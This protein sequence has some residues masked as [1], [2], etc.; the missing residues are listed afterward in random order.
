MKGV[1]NYNQRKVN[2]QTANILGTFNVPEGDDPNGIRRCFEWYEWA[3]I[4]TEKTSFQMSINPDPDDPRE[5]LTDAEALSYAKRLME[6]LGYND[7]PIVVYKHHDIERVHYH[8]V[9]IRTD[10]N[11]KKIKDSFEEKNL[12][13]LMARYAKMY[14]YV[15]G[16][17]G[18]IQDAGK[19]QKQKKPAIGDTV[20]KFDPQ[21]GDIRKQYTDLFD[22][23]MT[24]EFKTW[25]QFITIMED[26]GVGVDFLESDD[27]YRLTFQ[28]LDE[29][30]G[31]TSHYIT[32]MDLGEPLYEAYQRRLAECSE[33]REYGKAEKASRTFDRKRAAFILSTC[34]EYSRSEKHL[35]R[36][37]ERK[38]FGLS[39]SYN[40]EDDLFGATIIDHSAKRAYKLSE[41]DRSILPALQEAERPETGRWDTEERLRKEE[42]I[43]RKKAE[44]EAERARRQQA[45][46]LRNIDLAA[47]QARPGDPGA[48]TPREDRTDWLAYA[49]S[50]LEAMLTGKTTITRTISKVKKARRKKN[51]ASRRRTY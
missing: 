2:K 38:G 25:T 28:G 14:H 47:A 33:K 11:G 1:L 3:N 41:L 20:P 12:Q 23:A 34:I 51:T 18:R 27:R 29:D 8:V 44:R 50:I 35:K 6:G 46:I 9:S 24:Y 16:N 22:E 30:G 26:F 45:R 32:E 31:T 36:M 37:L 49:A 21:A 10:E 19:T 42:W 39:L 17:K 4:R 15:I 48:G 43:A 7:Q 40:A 5:T 13:R